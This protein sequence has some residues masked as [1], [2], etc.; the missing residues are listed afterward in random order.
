MALIKR[1]V[2]KNPEEEKTV[3]ISAQMHGSL[4]FSD[5]VN[6][7]ISGIFTGSLKTKGTLTIGSTAE[8]EA[9]IEGENV[10]IAG[11]VQGNIN[12]TKML[13]LMPTAA[14]KGDIKTSK[15]NIVEGAIFQGGCDMSLPADR[16]AD[17]LNMEEV[18]KYLEIDLREIETLANSGRIP[19]LKSGNTWKFERNKI[20]H[21]VSSE[22]IR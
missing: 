5:A 7:K 20:D 12:A 6:L 14:L 1:T 22:K 8:V 17:Y 16:S 19:G 3:E 4:V 21:W 15:L 9:N 10:V 2:P 18:S 11:K 13:V